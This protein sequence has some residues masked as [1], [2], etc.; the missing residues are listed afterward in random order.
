MHGFQSLEDFAGLKQSHLNELNITDPDQRSKILNASELLRD[1]ED[2]SEPEEEDRS[3]EQDKEPRDSGC[4][5]SSDNLEGRREETKTEEEKHEQL[6]ALQEQ[7]QELTGLFGRRCTAI[8]NPLRHHRMNRRLE[9]SVMFMCCVGTL[10]FV[11]HSVPSSKTSSSSSAS[12]NMFV[13]VFLPRISR[14]S[15]KQLCSYWRGEEGMGG[16]CCRSSALLVEC[17]HTW[18]VA[19]AEATPSCSYWASSLARD[20]SASGSGEA[21]GGTF[22]AGGSSSLGASP[23]S[24]E[25]AMLGLASSGV[26]RIELGGQ[27][28][29]MYA[30]MNCSPE[31]RPNE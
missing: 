30:S 22:G 21:R 29:C 7:L 20:A 6:D 5:E 12:M 19:T 18:R 2:E 28:G 24:A 4:F 10:V 14:V 25:A 26:L 31:V 23:F 11:V 16:S 27:E 3:R 13:V 8:K 1:S 15:V 9:R 17:E